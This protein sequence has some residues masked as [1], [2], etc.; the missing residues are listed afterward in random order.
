METGEAEIR[1][2]WVKVK[3]GCEGIYVEGVVAEVGTPGQVR[4]YCWGPGQA[5]PKYPTMA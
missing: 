4:G 3:S 2:Q 5:S 1:L